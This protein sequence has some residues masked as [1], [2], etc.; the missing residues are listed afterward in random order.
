MKIFYQASLAG[1]ALLLLFVIGLYFF[2]T[3]TSTTST[4]MGSLKPGAA[5][6]VA[7]AAFYDLEEKVQPLAQWKGKV[8]VVNFWATWCPPC[9]AEIP[10]FIRFQK[11]YVKQ[12]VQFVGIAIDQKSKVQTFAKEIGMNYPVLLGDLA[13]ID[14]ARRI[15]NTEGGLPYT[16]IVDRNGKIVTTQLGTISFE[17]LEATIKPYL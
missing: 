14:L 11:L 15:G 6:A 8:M 1:I 5:E 12:G 2:T 16:V 3:K 7:T 10:E 4:A 9:R 17:K 13:G